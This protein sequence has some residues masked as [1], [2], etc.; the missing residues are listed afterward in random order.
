MDKLAEEMFAA[1]SNL[2]GM[3]AKDI[4]LS[5]SKKF[6]LNDKKLRVS[7]L[8]T[9][10]PENSLSLKEGLLDAMQEIKEEEKL[11]GFF[12]FIVDILNTESHLIV[13]ENLS[14]ASTK[15]F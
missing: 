1:K 2:E 15:S 6:D 8:E 7:V 11:D 10:K 12:F 14:R 4:L 3:S 13:Q 9:T 5:D